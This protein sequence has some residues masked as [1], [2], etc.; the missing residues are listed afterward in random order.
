MQS[1]Y[2]FSGISKVVITILLPI[3][4]ISCS[5]NVYSLSEQKQKGITWD[6]YNYPK[7]EV[8]QAARKQYRLNGLI[9][10]KA[11]L[12]NG[13]IV[14]DWWQPGLQSTQ[15]KHSMN[16]VA[17]NDSTTKVFLNVA[18]SIEGAGVWTSGRHQSDISK[19]Q[20][21]ETIGSWLKGLRKNL[22]KEHV[23]LGVQFRS[24]NNEES[25]SLQ[26]NSGIYVMTVIN[27]SPAFRNDILSGDI[28]K[29][30][31]GEEIDGE[32]YF[33]HIL[34]KLKGQNVTITIFRKDRILKKDVKLNQ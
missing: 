8:F 2:T 34:Q 14:T 6:I 4:F 12:E 7:K 16:L 3:L 15:F 21:V 31:N 10:E 24:L 17:N 30:I 32:K 28:I 23:A 26:S 19:K 5:P 18:E 22:K 9:I 13:L 11:N 1:K 20:A 25:K 33:S 27:D 29:K